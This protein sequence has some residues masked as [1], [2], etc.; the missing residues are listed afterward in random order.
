MGWRMVHDS[1]I[2]SLSVPL[3]FLAFSD[4][5]LDSASRLCAV[6]RRSPNKSTYARGSVVLYLT[7]HSTHI[8]FFLRSCWR[9]C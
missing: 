8:F 9:L 5:Y 2:V 1:E 6:L 3:Q 4:A 7:F